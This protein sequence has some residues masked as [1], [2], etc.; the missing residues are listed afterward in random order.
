MAS[1]ATASGRFYAYY[2][3]DELETYLTKLPASRRSGTNPAQARDW[4]A[5]PNPISASS[6]VPELFAYTDGACSGNPGP[7]GWGVLLIARDG[8]KVVKERDLFGGESETTNNR[9]ELLA[10]INALEALQKPSDPDRGD[11]QRLCEER[12]DDLDPWLETQRLADVEQEAGQECRPMAT[13]GRGDPPPHRHL[14]MDQG[15]CRASAENEARD[16]LARAGMEPFKP[17][18][19]KGTVTLLPFLDYAVGVHLRADR[20]AGRQP[21]PA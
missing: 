10:A 20:S 9:M 21:R 7:G 3:Q 2:S 18:K 5:I 8:D 1:S 6:R 13:V 17:A 11:R 12:C 4:P 14:G 19:A 15:P 16:E